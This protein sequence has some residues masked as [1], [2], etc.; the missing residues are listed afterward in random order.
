MN[1]LQKRFPPASSAPVSAVDVLAAL[2]RRL[3]EL[4]ERRNV[5]TKQ[6][7]GL[8]KT[9][10]AGPPGANV[11]AEQAQ[12]LL[13]GKKFV[14]SR[15]K[16]V[17]ALA[18]LYAERSVIDLALKIGNS[19]KH[20][21]ATERATEI[22]SK[23]FPEIAKIELRRVQLALELQR[24]NAERE[25]LREKIS[26]AGGAGVLS[27]DGAELLGFQGAGDEIDWSAKRLIADGIATPA[28]IERMKHG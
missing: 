8:E 3:V 7:I 10:G 2:D 22:W 4:Q 14:M 15:D 27:T 28:E 21:L 12:A 17:S 25:K 19:Q 11:E 23:H 24:V 1:M 6:I 13:E 9:A 26:A 20:R 18:A 16:P 5:L